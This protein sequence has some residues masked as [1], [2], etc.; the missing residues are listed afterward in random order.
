MD[1]PKKSK[2]EVIDV[3]VAAFT[4]GR[5]SSSKKSPETYFSATKSRR[6]SSSSQRPKTKEES[7]QR[8][9]KASQSREVILNARSAK[10]RNSGTN[11]VLAASAGRKRQSIEKAKMLKERMSAAAFRREETLES[12][13]VN[14]AATVVY[15][16]EVS[17]NNKAYMSKEADAMKRNIQD[18]IS[19][20]SIRR[21]MHVE[22]IRYKGRDTVWLCGVFDRY[23]YFHSAT[24]CGQSGFCI[25]ESTDVEQGETKEY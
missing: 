13:R 23:V 18:K 11:K 9:E 25:E 24:V 8:L 20:A 19:Q 1:T 3:D 10:A 5:S 12:H 16:R 7:E 6:Q 17:S 22:D 21:D 14:A 2:R 15:A 4:P